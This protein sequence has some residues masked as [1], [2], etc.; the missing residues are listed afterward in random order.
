MASRVRTFQSFF[1]PLD[2]QLQGWVHTEIGGH[3]AKWQCYDAY[4]RA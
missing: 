3:E 2:L 1:G 4:C